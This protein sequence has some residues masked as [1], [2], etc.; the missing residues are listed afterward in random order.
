MKRKTAPQPRPDDAA[1]AEER[2]M[3]ANQGEPILRSYRLARISMAT[4]LPFFALLAAFHAGIA[5]TLAVIGGGAALLL[6]RKQYG[7]KA[8]AAPLLC[9][10]SGAVLGVFL[11]V[12]LTRPTAILREAYHGF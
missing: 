2:R 9:A 5:L 6:L 12:P 8:A 7:L 1:A 11:I 3:F 4:A 10:L